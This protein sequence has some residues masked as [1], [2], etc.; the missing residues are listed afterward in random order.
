MKFGTFVDF[1]AEFGATVTGVIQLLLGA[2]GLLAES[3]IMSFLVAQ[4]CGHSMNGCS[5]ATSLA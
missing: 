2:R 3:F 4:E 5:H 1:G